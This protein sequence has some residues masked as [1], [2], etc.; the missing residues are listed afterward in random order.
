MNLSVSTLALTQ[1]SLQLREVSAAVPCL[2]DVERTTQWTDIQ[3][4]CLFLS[5]SPFCVRSSKQTN[6]CVR[7]TESSHTRRGRERTLNAQATQ[8]WYRGWILSVG[9]RE[10]CPPVSR[11]SAN[12]PLPRS[13]AQQRNG[14]IKSW[15]SPFQVTPRK[16]VLKLFSFF[17]WWGE[18]EEAKRAWCLKWENESCAS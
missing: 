16:W 18:T 8:K 11:Y 15:S 4:T 10:L 17:F 6:L 1:T 12:T 2:L 14:S 9:K 5:F 7:K 13:V 3:P